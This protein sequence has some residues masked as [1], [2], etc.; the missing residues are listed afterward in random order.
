VF[1][2]ISVRFRGQLNRKTFGHG[3]TRKATER[4]ATVMKIFRVF[5]CDSV[6]KGV[7]GLSG[8]LRARRFE[9]WI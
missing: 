5:P 6:V 9:R 8:F 3:N 7:S 4:F 2:G 1:R